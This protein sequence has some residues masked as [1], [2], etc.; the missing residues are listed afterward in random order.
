MRDTLITQQGLTR[1]QEQLEHLATAG[2]RE[3]AER[4]RHA[5]AT[6]AN[7]AENPD[8]HQ[9]REDQAL[10]ERR[11]AVLQERIA[12]ARPVEPDPS[13]S[14]VDL[15]ERVRLHDLESGE[16]LEYELAGSAEADAFAGRISVAS[17]LGGALLGRSPGEVAVVD[18]PGGRRRLAILAIEPPAG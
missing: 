10:L 16:I 13:N 4:L 1:L 8:Y 9:A 12:W 2:R 11:I 15:G 17:P 18:A 14:V 7:A 3:I 6:D 5:L